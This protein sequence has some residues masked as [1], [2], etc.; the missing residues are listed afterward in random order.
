MGPIYRAKK[1]DADKAQEELI[2]LEEQ[3]APLITRHQEKISNIE[4]K[5]NEALE[6]MQKV[7]LTGFAARLDALDRLSQR[8][9]AIFIASLFIML[10]FIAIETAP[11]FVKL[12][13]PRSPYD[14]VLD[15]HEH[16]FMINHRAITTSLADS[17]NN[18][19]EFQIQT[20]SHKTDLAIKAEKELAAQAVTE[21]V[22]RL[23]K[24]PMLWRE[25]LRKGKLY[26]LE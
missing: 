12:I 8:S 22:E 2:A 14:Y 5:Q 23:K 21:H 4:T 26:G 11:I 13:T 15:K 18:Q 25:L 3:S 20:N 7:A 17:T 16:A 10:L 9:E 24:Q 19:L 1:A 6:S